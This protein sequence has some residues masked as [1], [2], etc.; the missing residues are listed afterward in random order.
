MLK[1]FNL[2]IKFVDVS[3]VEACGT[4]LLLVIDQLVVT[5]TDHRAKILLPFGVLSD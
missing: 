2:S 1:F 5:F 4:G 3:G